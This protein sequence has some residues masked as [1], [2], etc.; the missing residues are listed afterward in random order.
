[1]A[2]FLLIQWNFLSVKWSL[3]GRLFKLKLLTSA[4]SQIRSITDIVAT[5]ISSTTVI[6]TAVSGIGAVVAIAAPSIITTV[7]TGT[8]SVA[9]SNTY[10]ITIA[11]GVST[12]GRV[13][14][15]GLEG[16]RA[17]FV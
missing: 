4:R 12:I 16:D 8:I 2:Y 11:A 13:K 7:A 10:T 6:V 17:A 14:D 1:M 9:V 3:I 5:V 15:N